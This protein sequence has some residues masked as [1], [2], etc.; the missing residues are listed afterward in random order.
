MPI[1]SVAT[2]AT[3]VHIILFREAIVISRYRFVVRVTG[4]D[5]DHASAWHVTDSRNPNGLPFLAGMNFTVILSP[6]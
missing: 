4:G 3:R 2:I 1:M 6:W 5:I